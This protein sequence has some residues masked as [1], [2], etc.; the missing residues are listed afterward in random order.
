MVW[1]ESNVRKKWWGWGEG[2]VGRGCGASITHRSRGQVMWSWAGV[3]NPTTGNRYLETK[4]QISPNPWWHYWATNKKT[5]GTLFFGFPLLR[6]NILHY[7]FSLSFLGLPPFRKGH[8]DHYREISQW[9]SPIHKGHP[10]RYPLSSLNG[11]TFFSPTLK[12][13]TQLPIILE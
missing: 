11:L 8:L 3:F 10:C 13:R 9:L 6:D 4:T 1:A 5:P 12:I 7:G 2:G